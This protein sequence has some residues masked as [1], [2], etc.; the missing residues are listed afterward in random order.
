VKIKTIPLL[1]SFLAVASIISIGVLG[2]TQNAYAGVI[3]C[4]IEPSSLEIQIPSGEF[5][6]IEKS[7]TC[8]GDIKIV[9]FSFHSCTLNSVGTD[10]NPAVIQGNV[11]TFNERILNG[12]NT[13]PEQCF[14]IWGVQL[15]DN[16]GGGVR[17][18]LWI[19]QLK[20]AGELLPLDSTALFLAGI[21]SMTVWMIPTVLGLAGVGVYLVKFRKH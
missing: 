18:E 1:F 19:N 8:T 6:D 9:S 20:V 17:Q 13:S 10:G 5:I 16:N 21:Q 7:I 11:A 3:D 4:I 2:N 12:G 14:S 15:L